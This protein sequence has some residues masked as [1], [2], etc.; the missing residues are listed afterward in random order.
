M[1]FAKMKP[2]G[3]NP[4]TV[5]LEDVKEYLENSEVGDIWEIE[6]IEMSQEEYHSLQEF[7]GF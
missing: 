5:Y 2:V 6:I 7:K 3:L 1:K 4:V